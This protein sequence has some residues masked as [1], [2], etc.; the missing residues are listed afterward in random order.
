VAVDAATVRHMAKLARLDVPEARIAPLTEELS[1]ILGHMA[2]IA[3]IP[4][5]GELV[6]PKDGEM[7][8][9]PDLAEPYLEGQAL[10]ARA[11]DCREGEVIVPR[12]IEAQ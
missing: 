11:A 2:A 9:R 5:T 8:R 4:T 12:V 7:R 3:A 6:P 1:A 10:V